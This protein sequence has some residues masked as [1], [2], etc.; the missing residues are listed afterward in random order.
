MTDGALWNRSRC[1]SS[2]HR[3][4]FRDAC[5]SMGSNDRVDT[6]GPLVT[7]RKEF[8]RVSSCDNERLSVQALSSHVT[9]Q[10]QRSG[11]GDATTATATLA[12][13]SLQRMVRCHGL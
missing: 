13:G 5:S 10:A 1:T 7:H 12:P 8:R 6:A 4:G 11:A 2:I 9:T 3:I